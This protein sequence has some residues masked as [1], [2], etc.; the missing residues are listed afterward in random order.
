MTKNL[1]PIPVGTPITDSPNQ[2]SITWQKYL[3]AM[4]DD[5][6]LGNKVSQQMEPDPSD[7]D[8]RTGNPKLKPTGMQFVPN[9]C[10][11]ACVFQ[12]PAGSVRTDFALPFPAALPF[13]ALGAVQA[14]GTN[15][16]TIPV[17]TAFCQFWYIAAWS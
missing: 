16:L 11:I 13:E 5:L 8:S 17:G 7:I 4:G 10:M 9:G 14:T 15:R 1:F 6:L 3:K 2:F 12:R